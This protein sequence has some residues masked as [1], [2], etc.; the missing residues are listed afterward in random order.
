MYDSIPYEL[1]EL[2]QW[3]CFKI[4]EVE[5]GRKTKRPYNPLNNNMAKSND[6]TTWV[7]FD[8]AVSNLNGYDGIGF[9]FV[10][11]YVGIDLD[12]VGKEI[13]EYLEN[14]ETSNIIDQCVRNVCRDIT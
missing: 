6:K 5:N 11:P 12:K 3:C 10:E 13:Q 2:D 4:E 1:K 14:P 9:F 8:D 7:S